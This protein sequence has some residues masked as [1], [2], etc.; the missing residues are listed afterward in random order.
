MRWLVLLGLALP[1][2][3]IAEPTQ[4]PK[5]CAADSPVDE[6][7][8]SYGGT[9]RVSLRPRDGEKKCLLEKKPVEARVKINGSKTYRGMGQAPELAALAKALGFPKSDLR[10]GADVRDGV[11][12][13]D[14]EV[15]PKGR[16][17]FVRVK[18]ARGARVVS[19]KAKERD[20]PSGYNECDAELDVAITLV[21]K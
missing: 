4:L 10:I 17:A 7:C 13:I 18:M 19:G 14:L 16:D 3:A 20:V 8:K 1:A 21:G 9:Y 5:K 2:V 6:P 15:S 11:C 12:C